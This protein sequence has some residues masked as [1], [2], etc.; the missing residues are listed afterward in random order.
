MK[1]I[2]DYFEMS[3]RIFANEVVHESH[4]AVAKWEKYLD[5]PT[6]MDIN[7]EKMLRLYIYEKIAVINKKHQN[8]FYNNYLKI[9]TLELNEVAPK[10][11]F[12]F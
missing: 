4:T 8:D 6:N 1:F 5:R 9:R 3:L 10:F 2:R 12:R 7:I 11:A